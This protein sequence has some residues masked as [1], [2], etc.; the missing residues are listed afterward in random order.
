MAEE[1]LVLC[2]LFCY[3]RPTFFPSLHVKRPELPTYLS[4]VIPP[5]G[6]PYMQKPF[7]H[8]IP[9]AE[10]E[11]GH[12]YC[13]RPSYGTC[14]LNGEPV[15]DPTCC[16]CRCGATTHENIALRSTARVGICSALIWVC[17]LGTAYVCAC[18]VM[19]MR[20]LL[21]LASRRLDNPLI[22]TCKQMFD[23]HQPTKA[24]APSI[25]PGPLRS[26]LRGQASAWIC[27]ILQPTY[28]GT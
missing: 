2:E 28:L 12:R 7:M 4:V 8:C 16:R 23:D 26:T 13:A 3:T 19:R 15:S 18:V 10:R 27:I 14:E 11:V 24:A 25:G 21:L 20:L 1:I 6:H 22:E 9:K 5:M 17:Q